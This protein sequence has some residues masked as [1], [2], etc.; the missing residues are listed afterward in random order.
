MEEVRSDQL[1][2]Q[3]DKDVAD[4]MKDPAVPLGFGADMSVGIGDRKHTFG[5]GTAAQQMPRTNERQM[6]NPGFNGEFIGEQVPGGYNKE[7]AEVEYGEDAGGHGDSFGRGDDYVARYP[8]V[9]MKGVDKCVH[10][11]IKFNEDQRKRKHRNNSLDEFWRP[12]VR[13]YFTEDSKILLDVCNK[14]TKKSHSIELRSDVIARVFKAKYDFGVVEE[15]LLLENPCEFLLHNGI[16]VVDCPRATILTVYQESWV[17]TEGHLRVSFSSKL[18]IL[19]WE[20]STRIHEELVRI[21]LP[22]Q[23]Q[24]AAN[25]LGLSR[26][27]SE[28][29]QIAEVVN[30]LR[31]RMSVVINNL[32]KQSGG[33][34]RSTGSQHLD[35]K[36][37]Q[38][39]DD[40]PR[41]MD[42]M[43]AANGFHR[44]IGL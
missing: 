22:K 26:A 29:M 19:C 18:K 16:V 14:K 42:P 44:K 6:P 9:S 10:R 20:F 25:E 37:P 24:P 36:D 3:R 33:Q 2:A 23:P 31:D 43:G 7:G 12:F 21:N 5:A 34:T 1:D 35:D 15:R 30:E 38:D 11:I 41:G 13:E 28:Y 17:H 4:G 39:M 32:I 8:I 27:V 40:P